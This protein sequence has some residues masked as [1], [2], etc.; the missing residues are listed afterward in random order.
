ME[1]ETQRVW[2]YVTDSYVHRLIRN[3]AD[4]TLVELPSLGAT[5]GDGEGKEKDKDKGRGPDRE[6]ELEQDKLEAMGV[7]YAKLMTAQLEEQRRYYE[8][9]VARSK[10]ELAVAVRRGEEEE[11][12]WK[13]ERGEAE[14]R[15][16]EALAGV[17]KE[18]DALRAKLDHVAK[19]AAEDEARRKKE[20]REATKATKELEKELDAERTVTSSLA[21]NLSHLRGEMGK[22][23][24]ELVALRLRMDETAE[25][26]RDVMF[27][28]SARDQIEAEGGAASEAAGGDVSVPVVT[29]T[30]ATRRK[31]KR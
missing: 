29:P 8:D 7:E 4:G 17:A 16:D 2:D 6:D 9:E 22:R 1:L 11:L 27:A 5:K 24:E 12:R 26:M 31:K 10:D 18:R 28:L 3:R 25:Q 23:D 14:R 20:Q 30:A 19:V 21:E 13:R 15:L